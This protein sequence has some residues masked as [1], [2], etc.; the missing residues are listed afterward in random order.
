MDQTFFS[1][2]QIKLFQILLGQ[3]QYL[4]MDQAA[5]RLGVSTRTLFREIQGINRE[6]EGFQYIWRQ[7]QE[8][9]SGCP[10]TGKVLPAAWRKSLREILL[11]FIIQKNSGGH[12]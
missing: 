10:V 7:K 8:K 5:E 9:E 6:L 4:P 12:C 1:L 2:R 11:C 3:D